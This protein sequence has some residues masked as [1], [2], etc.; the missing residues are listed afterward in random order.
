MVTVP[1]WYINMSSP[2]KNPLANWMKQR[3]DRLEA[4]LKQ[5]EWLAAARF[6]IADIL[7]CDVLRMPDKLGELQN[8]PALK[9]YVARACIRPNFQKALRDQLAH[10]AA[11]DVARSQA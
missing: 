7:M 10:F 8:Y 1:W 9:A 5:R 2:Q 11:S 6:T 4:V 3:F